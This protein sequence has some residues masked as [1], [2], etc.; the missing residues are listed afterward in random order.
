MKGTRSKSN[1]DD[2]VVLEQLNK[3]IEMGISDGTLQALY[4]GVYKA[5]KK[6]QKVRV[7]LCLQ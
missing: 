5:A 7:N 4:P 3:Q 6:G 1:K 2:D